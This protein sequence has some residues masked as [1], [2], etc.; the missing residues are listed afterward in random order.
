[1]KDK[2]FDIWSEGYSATS[3]HGT[4]QFLGTYSAPTFKEACKIALKDK[5]WDMK[6]YNENRNTYWACRFFD[7]EVDARKSFG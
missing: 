6:Y 5:E 7:N 4:A 1:M 3:E 2:I